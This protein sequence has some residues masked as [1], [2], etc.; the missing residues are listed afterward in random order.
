M[1]EEKVAEFNA[2]GTGITVRVERR[3]NYTESVR[4]FALEPVGER[5][6]AI[7]ADHRS[8]RTL[9]DSGLT[10]KPDACVDD[11]R[12]FDDLLPVIEAAYSLEGELQAFPYNVSTPVLMFDRSKL[13]AAGLDPESPPQT[14]AELSDAAG[15]IVDSGVAP[16]GLVA[17]DHYGA[18]F[19][20]QYDSRRGTATGSP[21]NGRLGTP[22]E[23]V[24]FE[25]REIAE[26][27]LWLFDEV[28][29]G[30]ATWI[31][32]NPSGIDD[33][34]RL[35]SPDD[36]AAFTMNSSGAIGDVLRVVAGGSFGD[37][38][39]GVAPMPGPG[40]GALV[41]GGA[42]WMIANADPERVGATSAFLTWLLEPEVHAPFVAFTG[43]SPIRASEADVAVVQ[44]AWASEPVLRVAYDQL[45]GLSGDAVRAGP[46][47]GPGEAITTILYGAIT[48]VIEGGDTDAHLERATGQA[49]ALLRDYNAAS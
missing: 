16:F 42:F 17:Y 3:G 27:Y 37:A 36:G 24:D 48:A 47:W 23:S 6:D 35:V 15:R 26:S 30:R 7:M 34:L 25:R 14:L 13:R 40:H 20:T 1:I 9:S 43:F 46:A 18:W 12:A 11:G 45:R 19:V 2:L 38:E 5:P 28:E 21:D 31:G 39:V 49:N 41:G 32:G 29:S 44:E 22:V 10:V 8:L 33:L 4:E